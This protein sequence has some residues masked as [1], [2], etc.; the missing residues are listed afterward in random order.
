M[1]YFLILSLIIPVYAAN[2]ATALQMNKAFNS[3]M[4]L[5]PFVMNEQQ[6]KEKKSE[7]II[8]REL[9]NL[10]TS[11]K[12]LKHDPLLKQD[13]FSPS[14]LL[15]RE[16]IQ[17]SSEAFKKG[18]K[19]FALWN[20]R[21]TLSLC[22]DCHTRLPVDYTSSFQNGELE[23]DQK[24]L[25]D[26]YNLG[27]TLLI[28][29]RFVDAKMHFMRDIQDKL[30]Q[31]D[32]THLIRPLQ[33]VLLIETKIK[34]NP[35]AMISL[36]D[37]FIKNKNFPSSYKNQLLNWKE[38]LEIWKK[39]GIAQNDIETEKG[40][41]KFITEKLAPLREENFNETHKVDLL[42]SSG[43]LSRYFF[44][45]PS[46]PSA[47]ELNYWLGWIEK[48]LKREQFF[49]SGDLYLKQCIKEYPKH[50]IAKK[51]LEEYE[52]SVE[53]DFSGSG[54]THIPPEVIEE[55]ESLRGLIKK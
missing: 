15:I 5:L 7:K 26:P 49:S 4:E 13:L 8:A 9:S 47:P 1:K 24:K 17:E 40:L 16:G 41:Q 34:N 20:F 37:D 38:G 42:L 43:I 51:C 50:P 11:F 30:I 3:I 27:V 35:D 45:H 39:S 19:D 54:G 48:R 28:V 22:L 2:A 55:L 53:F 10:E 25:K 33:Q 31:K 18:K 12:L 32:Y 52:E 46:S 14:Y 21:E 29:R 6:F 36:I 23:I 44:I